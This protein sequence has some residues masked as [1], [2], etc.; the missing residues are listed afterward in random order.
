MLLPRD[1]P[2]W[3]GGF[4]IPLLLSLCWALLAEK[5]IAEDKPGKC[6]PWRGC[7]ADGLY[8]NQITHR[9]WDVPPAPSCPSQDSKTWSI[10]T[11]IHPH[12]CVS[13]TDSPNHFFK[14]GQAP[15]DTWASDHSRYISSLAEAV[16]IFSSKF[17]HKIRWQ[18]PAEVKQ[19]RFNHSSSAFATI[20]R[21]A[22]TCCI[23]PSKFHGNFGTNLSKARIQ[24]P[25]NA[26]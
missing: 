13:N 5:A 2:L 6:I 25:K 11:R 24:T 10:W 21:W 4:N 7:T 8:H 14:K 18:I 17:Y 9:A 23:D 1:C 15:N 19:T 26:I 16:L 20:C 22:P 12:C 3:T